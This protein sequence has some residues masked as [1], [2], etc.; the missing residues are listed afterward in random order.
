MSEPMPSRFIGSEVVSEYTI[1]A[2]TGAEGADLVELREV[3]SM[4]GQAIKPMETAR[5]A[6]WED[7]RRGKEN[8]RK[9][10]LGVF[11]NLGLV[12]V[13]SDYGLIL[14]AFTSAGQK[15]M[16]LERVGDEYVGTEEAVRYRWEQTAGGAVE[17]RGRKVNHRVLA[18]SLWIR[19]SDSLPLRISASFQHAEPHHVLR[20]DAVVEYVPS[21]L[22]FSTPITVVHRHYVDGQGI[23]ENL[24]TYAPFHLFTS[25]TSIRYTDTGD[26]P[27]RK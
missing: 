24:Y 1:G 18:G 11:T 6:L 23:T 19:K 22:G 26:G 7:A 17:F 16:R 8:A 14:L 20:D 2:L 4:N 13:A 12:D 25:D 10:L 21:P 9:H 15:D 5:R 27:G 3:V